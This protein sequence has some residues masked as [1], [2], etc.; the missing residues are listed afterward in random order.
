MPSCHEV[1][2]Q[3][4]PKH[5]DI[6]RLVHWNELAIQLGLEFNFRQELCTKY[7]SNSDRL[8][9]VIAQWMLSAQGAVTWIALLEAMDKAELKEVAKKIKEYLQS[10]EALKFYGVPNDSADSKFGMGTEQGSGVPNDP[11]V[12]NMGMYTEQGS[13]VQNDPATENI[14]V[15]TGQ[16]SRVPND[17]SVNRLITGTKQGSGVLSDPAAK[18]MEMAPEQGSGIPKNPAVN[19]LG[20]GSEQGSRALN[21]PSV[22]KL[23]K[24]SEQGSGL[25][26]DPADSKLEA[27]TEQG[28]TTPP[29]SLLLAFLPNHPLFISTSNPLE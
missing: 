18:N 29:H 8:D 6:Y 9:A 24:G 17:P 12:K 22:N 1:L 15:G 16:G 27:G 2:I 28:S 20:T 25:L 10:V 5:Q 11:A 14:E 4:R 13:K 23:G 19:K 26:N 21:D 7:L 3:Q